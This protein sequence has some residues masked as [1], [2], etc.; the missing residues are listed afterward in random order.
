MP[1]IKFWILALF[2]IYIFSISSLTSALFFKRRGV[3]VYEISNESLC[4]LD[5]GDVITQVSGYIVSNEEDFENAM[6]GIRKGQYVTMVVNG[7]PGGCIAFRDGDIGIKVKNVEEGGLIFGPEISGIDRYYI[8]FSNLTKALEVLSKRIE[9][10]R[11]VYTNIRKENGTLV[12]EVPNG[13][14]IRKLLFEGKFEGC[15]RHRLEV[16]NGKFNLKI[17]SN[18]YE[19]KPRGDT[20][21]LYNKSYKS[22]E[23]FVIENIE[24]R[25]VNITNTTLNLEEVFLTNEDIE[26]IF[27][28]YSSIKY[29][30]SS[31]VYEFTLPV[32]ISNSSSEK[33]SKIIRGLKTE[34][35]GKN[36]LLVGNLIY[37]FDGEE[38]GV[39]VLP[40][41]LYSKKLKSI[42]IVAYSSSKNKI[43]NIR[44]RIILS[45]SSGTI[46]KYK[47]V[48]RE[49][50]L[51]K[52]KEIIFYFVIM[53]AC[54][55]S[56]FSFKFLWKKELKHFLIT[57]AIP[58]FV[59]GT[60]AILQ[61]INPYIWIVDKE[62]LAGIIIST[63]F[64]FILSF[65]K[66]RRKKII[67]IKISSLIKLLAFVI[68]I[69]L[70]F[71]S[72]GLGL[73]IF[74]GLM[75]TILL[76]V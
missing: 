75:L 21:V 6:K 20:I 29:N 32:L 66:I 26:N 4:N 31:R 39:L 12:L 45:L 43:E 10:L 49:G 60:I 70:C 41:E 35:I 40:F 37:R 55:I 16:E 11:I 44:E 36:L 74:F 67:G 1:K 18:V 51:P 64:P 17:G 14:D 3:I 27:A 13:F 15:I 62:T 48:E 54:L 33:F 28:S 68:S 47:I 23:S 7:G 72:R 8:S 22:G 42:N 61:K 19:L 59:F 73:S 34:K 38:I 56:L 30:P 46:P 2:F 53:L 63:T 50:E 52:N 57:L 9:L 69:T 58:L 76:R 65:E 71:S 25:I 24:I 5:V